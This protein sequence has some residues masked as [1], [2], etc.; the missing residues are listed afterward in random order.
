MLMNLLSIKSET[1]NIDEIRIIKNQI[2]FIYGLLQTKDKI[3]KVIKTKDEL[4]SFLE[5]NE[6]ILLG[7]Q[8]KEVLIIKC[9]MCISNEH[10]ILNL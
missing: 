5:M 8:R 3:K 1:D 7:Y 10:M 2:N 6:P 4:E 9:I